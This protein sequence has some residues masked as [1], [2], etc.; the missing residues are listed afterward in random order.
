VN[1]TQ[2]AVQS[3]EGAFAAPE[4]LVVN[5]SGASPVIV[6][7]EH[8]SCFIPP[9]LHSLGLGADNLK[10]HIVWDPGAIA[11]AQGISSRLDAV[12]VASQVSRLVYDCNRPPGSQDAVPAKSE[13]FE[14]PGNQA[15]SQSDRDARIALVYEP[16]RASLEGVIAGR[17]SPGVIV[18]IHSFTRVYKGETR[19][20]E[21]GI[22]HDED[23]RLA[24]A[25]L[26]NSL[27]HTSLNVLR[28]EP[29]GPED[30]VT[31]TL[32]ETA[33]PAGLHNVMIEIRNDL[34]TTRQEQDA[35]AAMLSGW[36]ISGLRELDVAIPGEDA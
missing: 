30:G 18:T 15:L 7:C 5:A 32:R 10:S 31:H 29:Y 22:L 3:Q 36:I 1:L 19:E 27:R 25:M 2:L 35:M 28:N 13:I 24:D 20:V 12:L 4:P 21:L 33:L 17:Q 23:R 26:T 8:A 6:V 11:V 16:F 9:E 14:V 34:L